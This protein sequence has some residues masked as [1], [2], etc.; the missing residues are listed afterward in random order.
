MAI[1]Y[2]ELASLTCP[3]CR[4][5]FE[6]E[7]WTLLDTRERPDLADMLLS[8]AL[9]V[10][11]CP[12][13][14]HRADA[15]GPLLVHDPDGRR[16]YFAAPADA[17]EHVWRERARELLYVLV[18]SL[19]E[20]ARLP[21]LSDVQVEVEASGVRR[22]MMRRGRRF[23][24]RPAVAP[25]SPRTVDTSPVPVERSDVS[26]VPG[27][28]VAAI[29]ALIAADTPA[30]A[31]AVIEQ[32]PALTTPDADAVIGQLASAARAHGEHEIA[33]ALTE[34]RV[35]LNDLRAGTIPGVKQG[36]LPSVSP[37]THSVPSAEGSRL[38]DR[39]YQAFLRAES[40]RALREAV[41][42]YPALLEPWADDELAA[43]V[44]TALDEGNEH[45]AQAIEMRR[46]ALARLRAEMISDEGLREAIDALLRAGSE[47]EALAA[48]VGEYP[49]LLTDAA[50][51][52]LL[53]LAAGARA[54]G[55]YALAEYAVE[56]R[57]LLRRVREGL[58]EE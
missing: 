48:V 40:P 13:C 5:S 57:A 24:P 39:V 33:R 22:A 42:D 18:G 7:I 53:E 31:A 8:G 45:L 26:G 44:D 10:V 58:Q 17:P 56:C 52:A 55:D 35:L 32:H 2:A 50:Q 38:P 4:A 16:V 19:P 41:A 12:Q 6:A 54:R 49:A 3:V 9:N 1:S 21:Y 43:R 27:A 30:E 11:T 36:V 15:G 14:G 51:T 46:D 47:A 34:A 29:E 20:E 25:E 28:L 37:P 23:A